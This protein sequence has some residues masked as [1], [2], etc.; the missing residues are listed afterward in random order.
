[1]LDNNGGYEVSIGLM[2]MRVPKDD[3]AKVTVPAPQQSQIQAAS[4]R[5]INVVAREPD[6]V[7]G[8]INVIGRTSDEA[9]DEVE[10]FLD[11]AFLAGRTNVRVVHGTGMG[12]LRRSL[13]DYLKKH[14]HVVNITEPP[15]NEGGQG[16]TLVELKA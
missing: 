1:M 15:Y 16:A 13:R 9:R 3:I 6:M 10:R 11:Q 7:P 14:P 12:I 4:K 2:K 8:E 5:G